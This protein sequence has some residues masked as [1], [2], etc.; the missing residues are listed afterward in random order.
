M[1]ANLVDLVTVY[2]QLV[3]IVHLGPTST[4]LSQKS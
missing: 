2:S 1:D 3:K 4:T